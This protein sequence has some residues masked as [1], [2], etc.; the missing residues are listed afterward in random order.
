MSKIQRL[1]FQGQDYFDDRL[2]VLYLCKATLE[3][4]DDGVVVTT[5]YH[6]QAPTVHVWCVVTYRNCDRYPMFSIRHFATSD[7]A[8]AY[9][10][11]V[12]PETPL[13]SLHGSSPTKPVSY[14]EYCAWKTKNNLGE[15]D[16]S[17]LFTPGGTNAREAIFQTRE[18]FKGLM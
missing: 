17:K 13:I 6:E 15:Y 2:F 16:F 5:I 10:Q 3:T 7:S 12:E 11:Q 18:Q 8:V 14:Q 4:Q 1:S 9:L